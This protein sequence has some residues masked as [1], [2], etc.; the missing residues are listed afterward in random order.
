MPSLSDLWPISKAADV[1]DM[2]ETVGL[3]S[4][5]PH[6]YEAPSLKRSPICLLRNCLIW[7]G[8]HICSVHLSFGHCVFKTFEWFLSYERGTNSWVME[9]NEGW[10]LL[11]AIILFFISCHC[12]TWSSGQ[13]GHPM[14]LSMAPPP[15]CFS[16]AWVVLA[17]NLCATVETCFPAIKDYIAEA[18]GR[19]EFSLIALLWDGLL[20]HC[21]EWGYLTVIISN[22]FP[23]KGIVNGG[24]E[25]VEK[26]HLWHCVRL[27]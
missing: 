14:S 21:R 2:T 9:A 1:I 4:S 19:M 8:I 5:S 12:V 3:F 15:W 23:I 22:T 13:V 16:G 10:P 11:G 18:V 25:L 26:R 6:Y 20:L 27:C 17:L 24:E 7:F